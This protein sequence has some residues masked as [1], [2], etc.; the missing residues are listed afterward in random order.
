MVL[1]QLVIPKKAYRSR[2]QQLL[3]IL[4]LAGASV[5]VVGLTRSPTTASSESDRFAIEQFGARWSWGW[6]GMVAL[7]ATTA[8][9]GVLLWRQGVVIDDEGIVVHDHRGPRRLPWA[10]IDRFEGG[11]PQRR[12]IFTFHTQPVAYLTSSERVELD[13]GL[14]LLHVIDPVG[15][16]MVAASNRRRIAELNCFL[17]AARSRDGEVD[18]VEQ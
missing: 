15:F 11:E 9:A 13:F 8:F 17:V 10:S 16:G 6:W 12:W 4:V 3:A 1:A 18:T 2:L 14:R 7:V 5:A